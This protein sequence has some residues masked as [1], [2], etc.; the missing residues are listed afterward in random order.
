MNKKELYELQEG[1]N[2]QYKLLCLY[3]EPGE[4]G[5]P[6]AGGLSQKDFAGYAQQNDKGEWTVAHSPLEWYALTW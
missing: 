4:I 2:E 6:P 1:G 5:R 3:G